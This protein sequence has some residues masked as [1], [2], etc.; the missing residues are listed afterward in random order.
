MNSI[1]ISQNKLPYAVDEAYKTLR[2][3]LKFC[4]KENKVIV[5]TSC[6]A[7]EGKS[8]VSLNLAISLAKSNNKVLLVDTDLRKSVLLRKVTAGGNSKGLSHYLSG[9]AQLM[10]V[11]CATNISNLYLILAGPTPPNPTELL[12]GKGFEE[13]VKASR[14]VYD[15]VIIDSPPLGMVIDSAIIAKESDGAII[16]VESKRIS[17]SFA[18]EVKGQM[19]KSGCPILGVVMNKIDIKNAG[20]HYGKYGKYYGK[21]YG[22]SEKEN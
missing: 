2:T 14:N 17:R 7:G 15:Y 11:L 13:L 22:R 5:V 12:D 10:E 19:Q 8:S 18:R 4:G 21:Y 6:L 16:V 1:S 3:N 20:G 9:Q